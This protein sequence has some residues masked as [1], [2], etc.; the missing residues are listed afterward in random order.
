MKEMIQKEEETF[1]KNA[2]LLRAVMQFIQQ[3]YEL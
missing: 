1:R 2:K 3:E